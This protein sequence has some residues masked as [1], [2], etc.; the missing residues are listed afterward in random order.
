MQLGTKDIAPPLG[1]FI[2]VSRTWNMKG[3]Q[4][5]YPVDKHWRVTLLEYKKVEVIG[6]FSFVYLR[7]ASFPRGTA[8]IL[9]INDG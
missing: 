6:V 5:S 9:L 7:V 3:W 1:T 8:V 4:S 2:R